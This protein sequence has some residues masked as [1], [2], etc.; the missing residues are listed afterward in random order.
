[1]GKHQVDRLRGSD[2]DAAVAVAERLEFTRASD[3]TVQITTTGELP[4][5][6]NLRDWRFFAPSIDYSQG[7][8]IIERQKIEL[9]FNGP[10]GWRATEYNLAQSM[11]GDTLLLAAMRVFVR[12]ALGPEVDL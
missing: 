9:Q 7:G 12:N 8:P 5:Q 3:G 1:M 10:T 6:A 11:D 2:L 4:S